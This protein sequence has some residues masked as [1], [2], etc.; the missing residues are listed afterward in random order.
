M[1]K[2]TMVPICFLINVSAL[3]IALNSTGIMRFFL[4][5]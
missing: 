4:L 5:N 2:I 1:I 3:A